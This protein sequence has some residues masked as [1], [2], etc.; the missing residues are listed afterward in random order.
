MVDNRAVLEN[1][2]DAKKQPH[3]TGAA[4]TGAAETT[5]AATPNSAPLP[6]EPGFKAPLTEKQA[7]RANQTIKGMIISTVLTI[8]VVLPVILLNPANK[9]NEYNDRVDVAQIAQQTKETLDFDAIAPDLPEDWYVNYARWN[10]GTADGVAFWD[11]GVVIRD[12]AFAAVKQ[13]DK[14]NDSWVTLATDGSVPTGQKHTISDT[15]WTE[16]SSGGKGDKGKTS[17]VTQINGF[18]YVVTMNNDVADFLPE[19]AETIQKSAP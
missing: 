12:E 13:T 4:E 2:D 8:L 14:A 7:N 9:K 18:T 17:W 6:G 15:E 10:P 16:R 3:D 1:S 19:V 5:N 11:L